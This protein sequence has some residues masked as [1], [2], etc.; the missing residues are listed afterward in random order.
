M[1][2]LEKLNADPVPWLLAEDAA[3]PGVRYFALTELLGRPPDDPE[4]AAARRA[5]MDAGPIPAILAAQA[6]EGYWVEPGPGYYPKYRGTVW[7]VT[8][9]AQLGADG[10]DPRVSRAC[11]YVLDH[12]RS[13]YGGFA[14]DARPTGM[15]HC[16]QGNL[17]AA[18]I[19]LGRL[20]DPRLAQALDWLARSITGEGIAPAEE[21]HA[22][23]R[24]YR[25]GNRGP[26]FACSANGGPCAWGAVKA[27]L[28]L[29]KVPERE[30]TAVMRQAIS[31]GVEFLLGCDPATADYPTPFGTRP[32]GSWFRFGYPIAYVTDVLQNLEALT[33]LGLGSD[34]R[35]ARALD[36]VLSKQDAQGRW[37]MEYT[38]NGKTWADIEEKG[39]P[40]KWVTLRAL[41]V[42][43]RAWGA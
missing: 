25:S 4:V 12:T 18:L 29:G 9:L 26:G 21:P 1:A 38:Y 5:A 31:T 6:P 24:Y 20:G 13:P 27:M 36:L 32:S 23:V 14:M 15:I 42:L 41:R 3:N 7:Q 34:P 16:L 8:F 43:K 35:L 28:A 11:D 2:W 22:P 33:G 37:R 30:R 40:S 10:S 19:D 17:A 39:A